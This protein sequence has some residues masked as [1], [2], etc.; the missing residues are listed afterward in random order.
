MNMREFQDSMATAYRDLQ[1]TVEAAF[2]AYANRIRGIAADFNG[3]DSPDQVP[4]D[5]SKL[6]SLRRSRDV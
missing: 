4:Y 5:T 6:E 1:D 3:E 2:T